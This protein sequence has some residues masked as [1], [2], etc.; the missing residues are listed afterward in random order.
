M[1]LINRASTGTA[2]KAMQCIVTMTNGL[3]GR[4]SADAL[5]IQ[6]VKCETRIVRGMLPIQTIRLRKPNRHRK[7]LGMERTKET[8]EARVR[9]TPLADRLKEC[10]QRI[11]NMCAELRGPKMSIPVEYYDDDFYICTTLADAQATVEALQRVRDE[12]ERERDQLHAALMEAKAALDAEREKV[13]GLHEIT[14]VICTHCCEP[15]E[16]PS[17]AVLQTQLSQLQALVR[18]KEDAYEKILLSRERLERE[19]RGYPP[20]DN[21]GIPMVWQEP[22]GWVKRHPGRHDA[23]NY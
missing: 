2:L 6:V 19:M 12:F 9:E 16:I 13:K 20:V 4:E 21:E 14:K 22:V 11:G 5:G 3:K 7:G 17:K 8:L 15:M 10:Q 23:S 1:R 18:A